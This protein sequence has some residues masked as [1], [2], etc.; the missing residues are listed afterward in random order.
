[1]GLEATLMSVSDETTASF[2]RNLEAKK[3]AS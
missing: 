2:S 3:E 1:M